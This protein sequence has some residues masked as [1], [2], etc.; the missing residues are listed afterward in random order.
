MNFK[1]ECNV[2]LDKMVDMRNA[3]TQQAV[4]EQIAKV[5]IPYVTELNALKDKQI[6]EAKAEYERNVAALAA[7][8][9][10][11]INQL[12]TET[13]AAIVA[14]KTKI[15]RDTENAMRAK[16]DAFILNTSELVDNS[17]I[18]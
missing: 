9:Q 10:A 14:H 2:F 5:H 1:N 17:G 4:N 3:L 16:F 11:K 7:A 6:E 15:T 12:N 8:L 18:E 13:D